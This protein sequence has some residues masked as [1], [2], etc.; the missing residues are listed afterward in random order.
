MK[1]IILVAGMGDRLGHLTSDTPKCLIEVNGR[2][3]LEHALECL[4]KTG[5]QECVLVVGHLAEKIKR[6]VGNNFEG[7]KIIYVTNEIFEKT[8]NIYS[9]WLAEKYLRDDI[10]LLERDIFF[11]SEVIEKLCKRGS[12]DVVVVDDYT[13]YMDGTAVVAN[14][15][16]AVEMILKKEQDDDFQ[17]GGKLK[18][19]NIYKFSMKFMENCFIPTLNSY[20]EDGYLN[21]F[22]E[23]VIS[24]VIKSNKIQIPVLSVNGLKWFEIDTYEDLK[25]C[26]KLFGD[27]GR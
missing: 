9:L 26:E 4:N 18:T 24:K 22:Y 8:G 7:I 11:E 6:R 15:E 2:T 27:I 23:L 20:I 5:I 19:V 14:D 13:E 21:E 1:A 16:K 3:I 25:K 17:Y 10:I 12:P